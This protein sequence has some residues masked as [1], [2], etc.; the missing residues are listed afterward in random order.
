[1]CGRKELLGGVWFE[2]NVVELGPG[3]ADADALSEVEG[4]SCMLEAAVDGSCM[5]D[6]LLE[7]GI[8]TWMACSKKEV[9][10]WAG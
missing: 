7:V 5:E 9:Q 3:I 4:P 1:M 2:L 10:N 6:R 8:W